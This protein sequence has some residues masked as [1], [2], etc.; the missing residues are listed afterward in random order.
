MR[1]A[2]AI[3]ICDH[4]AARAV[5]CEAPAERAADPAR[6]ARDHDD[7]I[8]DAHDSPSSWLR[9]GARAPATLPRC[10]ARMPRVVFEREV[11]V[12]PERAFASVLDVARWPSWR[13]YGP[14]PAI[15]EA[16]FVERTPQVACRAASH[17]HGGCR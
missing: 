3:A 14:I 5:G 6:S 10:I 12:S 9:T 2:L 15:R 16:R 7:L 11:P 17:P 4:D 8:P 1:R 13:G